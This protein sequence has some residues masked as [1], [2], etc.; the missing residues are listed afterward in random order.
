MRAYQLFSIP[1]LPELFVLISSNLSDKEKIYLLCCSKIIYNYKSLLKF[2]STYYLDHIYDRWIIFNMRKII[3]DKF[4][5]REE[6]RKL[7]HD[8]IPES[9]IIKSNYMTWFVNNINTKIKL[10]FSNED[11][12]IQIAYSNQ[13]YHMAMRIMLKGDY[14]LEN[15]NRALVNSS[16]KGYLEIIKILL[17]KGAN[18]HYERNNALIWASLRGY[19]DIVKLLIDNH[20]NVHDQCNEAIDWSLK[21][22]HRDVTKL[23]INNGAYV[24][25][26]KDK[27]FD[28]GYHYDHT[29]GYEYY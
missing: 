3:I 23:L 4:Y 17:N 8:A 29:E 19:L 13:S 20:A 15:I 16:K 14:S 9:I 7:M 1:M 18:V 5:F 25:V 21:N 24:Q 28:W 6:I 2:D 10:L 11:E 22:N 12:I 26:V 27:Y